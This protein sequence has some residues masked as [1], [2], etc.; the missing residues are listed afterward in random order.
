MGAGLEYMGPNTLHI[1]GGRDNTWGSEAGFLAG[2][3]EQQP[4]ASVLSRIKSTAANV[5]KGVSDIVVPQARAAAGGGAGA[6][7]DP[8]RFNRTGSFADPGRYIGPSQTSDNSKKIDFDAIYN[9]N[10]QT[11]EP[12]QAA[13]QFQR[14]HEQLNSMSQRQLQGMWR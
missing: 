9:T 5:A 4:T 13:T 1:G 7:L 10:I 2:A 8:D 3:K 11:N 12:K 14:A 6:A